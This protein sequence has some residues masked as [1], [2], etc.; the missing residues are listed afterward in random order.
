MG[1]TDI[2]TFFSYLFIYLFGLLLVSHHTHFALPVVQQFHFSIDNYLTI[3]NNF[4]ALLLRF[5]FFSS[6]VANFR[7][8]F[9]FCCSFSLDLYI[10]QIYL[11]S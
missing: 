6:A 11:L 1:E 8:N 4:A 9:S 3:E 5:S 2:I 10:L 7:F